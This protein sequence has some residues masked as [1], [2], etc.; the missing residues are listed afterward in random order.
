MQNRNSVTNST[1]SEKVLYTPAVWLLKA[2]DLLTAAC[3]RKAVSGIVLFVL[4]SH[5]VGFK[6][7]FETLIL[8]IRLVIVDL[9]H[10]EL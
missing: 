4:Q 9:W 1:V 5:R 3:C 2:A 8:Q 7:E 10:K 6:L